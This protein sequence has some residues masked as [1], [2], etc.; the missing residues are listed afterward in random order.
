MTANKP[1]STSNEASG[2]TSRMNAIRELNDRFRRSLRGGRV[3]ITAGVDALGI[4]TVQRLLILLRTFEAFTPDNDPNGEHDFGAFEH[5]TQRFFWKIDYYDRALAFGSDDPSDPSQT[6][7]VLT[8]ML[9]D[10]Y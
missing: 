1:K 5:D 2:S 9:A 8:L 4:E 3:V 6:V 7:R 10:E